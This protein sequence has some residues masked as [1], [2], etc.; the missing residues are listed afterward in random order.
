[1]KVTR[2]ALRASELGEQSMEMRISEAKMDNPANARA[3][4]PKGGGHLRPSA[5]LFVAEDIPH[6]RP[7]HASPNGH[8][9]PPRDPRDFHHGLLARQVEGV[10]A[11]LD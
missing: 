3:R 11:E 10:I 5:L 8:R 7:P 1:M 2:A 4:N 6:R 9:S